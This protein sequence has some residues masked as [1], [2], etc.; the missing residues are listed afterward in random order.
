[1]NNFARN[2]ITINLIGTCLPNNVGRLLPCRLTEFDLYN[3]IIQQKISSQP[4]RQRRVTGLQAD[5]T[6]TYNIDL[7]YKRKGI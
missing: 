4:S 2:R 3:K 5:A 1:M 7:Y 6:N